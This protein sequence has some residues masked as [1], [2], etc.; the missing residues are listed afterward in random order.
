MRDHE[1]FVFPLCALLPNRILNLLQS[2]LSALTHSRLRQVDVKAEHF[3]RQVARIEQ[4]R[5]EWERKYGV[6]HHCNPSKATKAVTTPQRQ[7]ASLTAGSRR[8]V[9]AVQTGVGRGGRSDGE[10]GECPP[11]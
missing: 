7:Y 3:E 2:R 11:G 5:D 6:S 10:L 8:E 1:V 9:P 4:D